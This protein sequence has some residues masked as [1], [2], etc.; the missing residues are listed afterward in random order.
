VI[1]LILGIAGIALMAHSFKKSLEPKVSL[2]KY[3][4]IVST[5]ADSSPRYSFLPVAIDAEAEASAFYHIPGFLQG[6]DVICLRQRFPKEKIAHL[7]SDLEQ[8]GR[9]EVS[10]FGEIPAPTCYP[11]YGIDKPSGDNLFEGL[12]ELPDGFRIF[13]FE[14]DLEDIKENWNHN[15]LAFTAV[16][17][18]EREVVYYVDNW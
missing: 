12:S 15:F 11:N 13:L 7:L 4:E 18:S 5:R 8:S 2:N 9:T 1:L 3:E 6:G 16:S 10:D 14:S 17:L